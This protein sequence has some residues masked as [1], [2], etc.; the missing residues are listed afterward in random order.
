MES[1]GQ[2][3]GSGPLWFVVV[4]LLLCSLFSIHFSYCSS[5]YR[6][7]FGP[8]DAVP[9]IHP[10]LFVL[11]AGTSSRDLQVFSHSVLSTTSV[12]L[13]YCPRHIKMRLLGVHVGCCDPHSHSELVAV[14]LLDLV[15]L[16]CSYFIQTRWF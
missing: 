1:R 4:A 8:F 13:P 16:L 15:T 5:H 6:Y 2:C 14:I 3:G 10:K 12:C 7:S 11:R 9:S